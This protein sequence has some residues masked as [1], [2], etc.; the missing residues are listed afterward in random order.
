MMKKTVISSILLLFAVFVF[1]QENTN[2]ITELKEL[3]I[4]MYPVPKEGFSLYTIQLEPKQNEANFQIELYAEKIEE[5]DCN[6]Y[7]LLGEFI[8]HNLEGWGYSYYEFNSNGDI[9]GTRMACPNSSKHEE[10]VKSSVILVRYNS[11][12]PIVVYLPNK[13][14][15]KY[16]IWERNEVEFEAKQ[17]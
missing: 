8:K 5:V 15:L 9:M 2:K 1:S 13:M 7:Q 3:D 4:S 6:K 12:I 10:F 16:K 17:Q 11:N 14:S